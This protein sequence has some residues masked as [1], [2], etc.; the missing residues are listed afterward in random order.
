MEIQENGISQP[1]SKLFPK[2][3]SRRPTEEV[4]KRRVREGIVT[5][6]ET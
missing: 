5:E 3:C 2:A 1:L 4:A 6:V